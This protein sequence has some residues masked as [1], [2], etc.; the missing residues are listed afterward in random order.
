[1][2]HW[3]IVDLQCGDNFCSTQSE[4]VKHTLFFRFFSHTIYHE[5]LDRV[6]C[7][8]QQVTPN[9]NDLNFWG[10]PLILW[11]SREWGLLF[12]YVYLVHFM[13][14]SNIC[15]CMN[16]PSCADHNDGK[17]PRNLEIF[18]WLVLKNSRLFPGIK[19]KF[20]LPPK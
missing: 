7:A 2:F 6:P 9:F 3:N 1:M 14:V 12:K 20:S 15:L 17:I 13:H 19:T 4:S 5:I 8:M 10:A 11:A 16:K 18:K